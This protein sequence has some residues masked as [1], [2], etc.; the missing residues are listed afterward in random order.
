VTNEPIRALISEWRVKILSCRLTI[1]PPPTNSS[2]RLYESAAVVPGFRETKLAACDSYPYRCSRDDSS[3]SHFPKMSPQARPLA[4][5]ARACVVR[6]VIRLPKCPLD[7]GGNPISAERPAARGHS[8]P[9]RQS[10]YG[11][12]L[13]PPGGGT[14]RTQ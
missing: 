5:A 9:P 1:R 4:S 14:D 12:R 7:P 3:K 6:I 2:G 11:V 8:G 10:L 13:S